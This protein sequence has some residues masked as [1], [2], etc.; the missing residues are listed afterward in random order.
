M[1]YLYVVLFLLNAEPSAK[2][3]PMSTHQQCIEAAT[4]HRQY[5]AEKNYRPYTVD[6]N[7]GNRYIVECLTEKQLQNIQVNIE[8]KE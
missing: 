8:I 4:V 1:Y 6:K 2:I 5:Y 7:L 3:W